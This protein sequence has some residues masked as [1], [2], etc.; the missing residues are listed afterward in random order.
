M[1]VFREFEIWPKF[2]LQLTG[3]I[4]CYIVPWY[5]ESPQYYSQYWSARPSAGTVMTMF[6][7]MIHTGLALQCSTLIIQNL[8]Y[9]TRYKFSFPWIFQS[10]HQKG[11][12]KDGLSGCHATETCIMMGVQG[13]NTVMNITSS[14][15]PKTRSVWPQT[16]PEYAPT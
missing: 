6:P 10:Q 9:E 13:H 3:A 1:G 14:T 2:Y 16:R 5:I 15:Q 7:P 4:S 12:L 11:Y 8:F